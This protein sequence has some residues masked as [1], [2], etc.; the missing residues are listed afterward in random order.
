VLDRLAARSGIDRRTAMV[1]ATLGMLAIALALQLAAY[2]NGGRDGLSDLPHLYLHRGIRPGAFPYLD[3]ALEYPVG[4]GVLLWI[5]ASVGGGPLGV[6]LVTALLASIGCVAIT[7][8]LERWHGARAWRWVLAPP[9]VLYAF[10]NWDVFAVAA[11]L[12]GL[13]AFERRADRAAGAALGLGAAIKLFPA[14]LVVP[15]AV[16][17]F[18]QGGHRDVRRLVSTAAVV[19]AAINL[20]LLV[21]APA[22]W[23][24]PWQFQ[25]NRPPTWGSTWANLLPHLG[26]PAEGPAGAHLGNTLAAVTLVLGIAALSAVSWRKRLSSFEITGA[27]LAVL[28][29]TTKIYSPTYDLWLVLCFV[30]VPLGS[31]V[32][33]AF[34][35]ADLAI[36]VVVYGYFNGFESRAELHSVL[37]ALVL[38]RSIVLAIVLLGALRLVPR[39][40]PSAHRWPAIAMDD[41]D[42]SSVETVPMTLPM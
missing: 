9:L 26:L 38:A 10:Q 33:V 22:G 42:Q 5:A 20:P 23:W 14:L 37:P 2:G 18:A 39:R 8:I 40:G 36:Y 28:L 12:A 16:T 27:T 41:G 17:R 21:A 11:L 6:L 24:W 1:V 4:A 25:S 15:L 31:K 30:V 32:W 35:A 7:L 34:C 29:L 13:V 19:F 3:R